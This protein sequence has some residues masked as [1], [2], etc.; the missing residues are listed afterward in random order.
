MNFYSANQW[1][2]L[3]RGKI[4]IYQSLMG[5]RS[6][7]ILVQKT[8]VRTNL[9]PVRVYLAKNNPFQPPKGVRKL[10]FPGKIRKNAEKS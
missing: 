1:S 8:T 7:K 9:T 3:A 2:L 6:K 4:I 5:N 10:K